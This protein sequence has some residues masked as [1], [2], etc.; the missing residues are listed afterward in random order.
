M[1]RLVLF[2]LLTVEKSF[3]AHFSPKSFSNITFKDEYEDLNSPSATF[4]LDLSGSA[5]NMN[6]DKQIKSETKVSQRL[7]LCNSAAAARRE[8]TI[9]PFDEV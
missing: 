4:E 8:F 9:T 6:L 1:L 2:T 3:C 5:S 7:P